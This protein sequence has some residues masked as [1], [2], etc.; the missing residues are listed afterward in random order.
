MNNKSHAD[1]LWQ[2]LLYQSTAKVPRKYSFPLNRYSQH[3]Y[4]FLIVF[5]INCALKCQLSAIVGSVSIIRSIAS[6]NFLFIIECPLRKALYLF[7]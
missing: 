2:L 1:V 4:I 5:I 6:E 3:L 7:F